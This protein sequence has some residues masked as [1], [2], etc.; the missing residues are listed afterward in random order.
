[1]IDKIDQSMKSLAAQLQACERRLTSHSDR[2]D[3]IERAQAAMETDVITLKTTFSG[4]TASAPTQPTVA[5]STPSALAASHVLREL[6]LRA[7]RKANLSISGLRP[8]LLTDY[9]LVT[10]LLKDELHV[11]VTIANCIRLEKPATGRASPRLLLVSLSSNQDA[12]KV[13][14]VA[15]NLRK[16]TDQ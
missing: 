16:S 3:T 1:M 6:D 7:S 9:A 11:D 2:L 5:A 4:L 14:R 13:L 8:S 10:N 15:K 12:Q